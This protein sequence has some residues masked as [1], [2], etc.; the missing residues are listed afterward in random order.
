MDPG[1]ANNC[2]ISGTEELELV[3]VR[4]IQAILSFT[5][6]PPPPVILCDCVRACVPSSRTAS[7]L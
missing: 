5:F 7:T 6:P 2:G 4:A 3:A 1:G